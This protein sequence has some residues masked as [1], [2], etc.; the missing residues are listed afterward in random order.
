IE[1][2]D[3]DYAALGLVVELQLLRIGSQIAVLRA[4]FQ[5]AIIVPLIRLVRSFRFFIQRWNALVE[6]Q[7]LFLLSLCELD[8][9]LELGCLFGEIVEVPIAGEVI[10]QLARLDADAEDVAPLIVLLLVP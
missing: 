6:R 1:I 10:D 8:E 3:Q 5:P 7:R 4:P 2:A 9:S